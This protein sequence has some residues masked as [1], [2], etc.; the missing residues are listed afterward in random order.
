MN[1][2]FRLL[3]LLLRLRWLPK[4]ADPLA[5]ATLNMRVMPNDLDIY[6]HVNNGRYLSIMDLGRL[7]LMAVT[8][9]L[10]PIRQKKWVPLLGSVKI[11]F[12]KPLTVFQKYTLTTQTLYWDEKWIYLEQKV[13]RNEHVCAVALIKV[14]F[15][16]KE[17]KIA[18]E[19]I[20]ALLPN[21]PPAPTIPN[22]VKLW[23]E[24]E[25]NGRL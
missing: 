12:L 24:A 7:H 1:L 13:H 14:L 9:L 5:A 25:Q 18:P 22:T 17:G 19:K 8:G 2:Y 21:P 4:Q 3:Y 15:I 10:K 11:H 6:M 20:L 16:G 23:Q